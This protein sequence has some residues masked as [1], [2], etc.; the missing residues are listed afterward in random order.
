MSNTQSKKL[1][2]L[3]THPSK[4]WILYPCKY[5]KTGWKCGKCLYGL[6]QPQVNSKCGM[7]KAV[8]NYV[9]FDLGIE[10]VRNLDPK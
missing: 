6:V 9:E 8:V 4:T 1:K 2:V 5:T 7:C 10:F 3:C